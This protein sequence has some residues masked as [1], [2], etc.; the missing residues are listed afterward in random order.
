VGHLRGSKHSISPDSASANEEVM[1]L[2][3]KNKA[4]TEA[5]AAVKDSA[6]K[7]LQKKFDMVWYARYR[8][9]LCFQLCF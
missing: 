1:L 2:R 4:L 7:E 9:E 6:N 5:L 8:C 3:T